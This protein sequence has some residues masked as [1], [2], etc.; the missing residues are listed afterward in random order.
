MSVSD[1]ANELSTA[2]FELREIESRIAAKQAELDAK[3][4][5]DKNGRASVRLEIQSAER[6]KAAASR[7]VKAAQ[8]KLRKMEQTGA[9]AGS[10]WKEHVDPSS[11]KTY[12]YN[13]RTGE[14]SWTNPVPAQAAIPLGDAT[15][16]AKTEEWTAHVD[17]ASG[18]TYYYNATTGATSWTKPEASPQEQPQAQAQAQPTAAASDWTEHTDPSSGRQYYYNAKTG[19][20]SWTLPE[21]QP[22]T[23][24]AAPQED[25]WIEN[26]DP[27]SGQKYYYNKVTC[28]SSWTR[29]AASMQPLQAV[30]PTGALAA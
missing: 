23:Q 18:N 19:E 11:G 4:P 21:A 14:S 7:K 12:Y 9:S 2:Q 8:V 1:L 27:S 26:V 15:Q 28:E 24:A 30:Q 29:P 3:A 17:P 22:Q 5:S 16:P 20:T 25:D 6:Q 10:D 13:E